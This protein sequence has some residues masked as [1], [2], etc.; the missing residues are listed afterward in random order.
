MPQAIFPRA[1]FCAYRNTI[2]RS[3]TT[4]LNKSSTP[5]V[6]EHQTKSESPRWSLYFYVRY[7]PKADI[8]PCTAHVRFRG[9]SGH[10]ILRCECPLM[11]QSQAIF[12][13]RAVRRYNK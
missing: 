1:A 13:F 11:T 10:D 5:C 8:V 4:E 12:T 9:K 7:W 6:A 2:S 3:P